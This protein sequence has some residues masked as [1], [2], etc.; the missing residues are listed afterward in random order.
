MD[1]DDIILDYF[2]KGYTYKEILACL[3]GIHDLHLSLRQ[4]KRDL[5]RLNLR[6]RNT[7]PGDI[8]AE[9]IASEIIGS[10]CNL[11][12]RSMQSKLLL[13]HEVYASR[14][15]I[16]TLMRELDP[17][18]VDGRR[19]HKLKR[20]KYVNKGPNYTWHLDGYD[21]LK[22][23]GLCLH[24]C[25][26]GYSRKIMWLKVGSTNN[27]PAVILKYYLDCIEENEGIPRR[28]R[29]DRGTENFRIAATQRFLR[30]DFDDAFAGYNSFTFGKSTSNQRIEA[31]WSK[32]R[33]YSSQ[34]WIGFFK[35][36][37]DEGT[38]D[39]TDRLALECIRFCFSRMIQHELDVIKEMHNSHR[40]RSYPTQECP[41]GR[42]NLLYD[43]PF[44]YGGQ[45][46][47]CRVDPRDIEIA[48]G[49]ETRLHSYGCSADFVEIVFILLG[50]IPS[51]STPEEGREL[52]ISL[53]E[54]ILDSERNQE[55]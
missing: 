12:Y 49:F 55:D 54:M 26:D 39:N 47:K 21:K 3:W 13:T 8:L 4:L 38:L 22:P 10:G 7:V 33:G 2:K 24:G 6:R 32:L 50:N 53:M 1:R 46:Y 27:D 16:R 45:D 42:P 15:Q 20:R 52:Y 14:E 25:I 37:I 43:F 51:P 11:G 5:K 41:S 44:A 28:I 34:F 36:M 35:D 9:L 23:Y 30:E 19:R 48:R 29:S 17:E 31:W 18:G 40:I